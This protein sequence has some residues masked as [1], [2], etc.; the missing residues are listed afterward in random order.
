MDG[1]TNKIET[2]LSDYNEDIQETI[3][4]YNKKSPIIKQLNVDLASMKNE[5]KLIASDTDA[6]IK[7]TVKISNVD[8]KDEIVSSLEDEIQVLKM[9]LD[10]ANNDL[11]IRI[12]NNKPITADKS[13]IKNIKPE[14]QLA[15]SW[16]VNLAALSNKRK[17]DEIVNRLNADG[18]KP[19]I[20]EVTV[21]G[22]LIYRLSVGGFSEFKQ[23]ELFVIIAEDKYGMKGGWIKKV[24]N[25]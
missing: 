19:S 18:L 10:K 6:E 22:N 15:I 13:S 12:S 11:K 17:V 4:S 1:R 2:I 24:S 3:E 21:N 16:K 25:G 20:D 8:I 5:L 14:K 23:A 9:Q 7:E